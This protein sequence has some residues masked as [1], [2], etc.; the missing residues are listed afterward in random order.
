MNY[1]LGH[2]E[3]CEHISAIFLNDSAL[4]RMFSDNEW[5][6]PGPPTSVCF[7]DEFFLRE[8]DSGQ[9]THY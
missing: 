4:T 7:L 3:K 9:D 2:R 8:R 5:V 1:F 6:T